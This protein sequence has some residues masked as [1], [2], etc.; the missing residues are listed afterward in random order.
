MGDLHI[1]HATVVTMDAEQTIISDGA[2]IAKDARIV[3]VGPEAGAPAARTGDDV[4]D[5]AG[6]V[7]LPG[8]IN[9][10]T[11]LAMTLF[12]QRADDLPLMTW[13]QDEIWPVEERITAEDVY[14]ASLLGIA[15][16]LRAGVTRTSSPTCTGTWR[17]W[18]ARCARAASVPVCPAW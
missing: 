12:R 7:A 17:L 6:M 16:M 2:V 1:R 15:E 8:F 5:G 10:H 13:L 18:R 9:G 11:H 14:W 3:Y 4:I